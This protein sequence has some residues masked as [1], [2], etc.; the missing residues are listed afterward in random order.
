MKPADSN[1]EL[2][3][4]HKKN[5][6][7]LKPAHPAY[8]DFSAEMVMMLDHVVLTFVYAESLRQER[9]ANTRQSITNMNN[10][11]TMNNT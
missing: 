1:V 5:V 11:I 8:L 4:F 9:D 3:R 10:M 7:V 2:V 6:G